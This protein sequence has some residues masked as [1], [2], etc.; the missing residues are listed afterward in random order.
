VHLAE[1]YQADVSRGL[2]SKPTD[3]STMSWRSG[4]HDR[5]GESS[6][7]GGRLPHHCFFGAI[8][9]VIA[10][11]STLS[12]MSS[13]EK[14]YSLSV[15]QLLVKIPTCA[16]THIVAIITLNSGAFSRRHDRR[17]A[18]PTSRLRRGVR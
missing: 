2:T 14:S 6:A 12:T 9:A 18:R 16:I 10:L 13:R 11:L 4:G 7:S 5:G 8:G 1:I 15:R 3:R 17:Q